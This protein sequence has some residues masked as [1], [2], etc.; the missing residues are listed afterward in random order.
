VHRSLQVQLLSW[1]AALAILGAAMRPTFD[2]IL[3]ATAF[4]VGTVM[5]HVGERLAHPETRKASQVG[6]LA[7]RLLGASAA[8]GFVAMRHFT[9]LGHRFPARLSTAVLIAAAVIPTGIALVEGIFMVATRRARP[10]SA[11]EE[12]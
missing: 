2:T 11:H 5:M 4:V 7:G 6:R 9:A 3:F 8:W 10:R 1:L 12:S